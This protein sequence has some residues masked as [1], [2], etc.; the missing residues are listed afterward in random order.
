MDTFADLHAN[1]GGDMDAFANLYTNKIHTITHADTSDA[2]AN[3]DYADTASDAHA[4]LD[5]F[6]HQQLSRGNAN[7]DLYTH[8]DTI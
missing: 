7:Q 4:N 5:T 8:L 6:A 2:H 3:L 1:E